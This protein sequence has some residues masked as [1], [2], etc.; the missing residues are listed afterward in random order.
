MYTVHHALSVVDVSKE[1]EVS[2]WA[3][4]AVNAHGVPHLV[5]NNAGTVY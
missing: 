4:A 3:N 5:I 1:A 2:A